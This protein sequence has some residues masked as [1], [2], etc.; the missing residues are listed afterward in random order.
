QQH[1]FDAI[2]GINDGIALFDKDERLVLFNRRCAAVFSDIANVFKP[3][4]GFEDFIRALAKSGYYGPVDE[5]WIQTRLHRFRAREDAEYA[6]PGADGRP[7]WRAARHHLTS[8]GETL[9]VLTDITARKRAEAE[10]ESTRQLLQTALDSITDGVALF[11]KDE[12]LT[13]FN[14]NFVG[15]RPQ[16][17]DFVKPGRTFAEIIGHLV[18]QGGYM[19][20]DKDWMETRLR[21]FRALEPAELHMCDPDGRERWADVRHYRTRDGGTFLVRTVITTRKRAEAE[22]ESAQQLL[23]TALDS[24]TGGVALF[25]KDERLVM[26][27]ENYIGA[28]P[29][30]RDFVRPGLTIAEIFGHLAEQGGFIDAEVDWVATRLRQFRALESAEIH[31]RDPDGRERWI[32]VRH[33]R[34]RDGGTFLVRADITERKR[35]EVELE[36]AR[37]RFADAIEGISDGV[38]LF[39]KDERLVQ[40]NRRYA[41]VMPALADILKPGVTFEDIV[42]ALAERSYYGPVDEVWITERLRRFRNLEDVEFPAV[43]PDGEQRWRALRHYRTRDGGTLLIRTDITTRKRAEAELES[44]RQLLQ[45]ALDSMTDG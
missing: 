5:A 17:R 37:Q 26:F 22:R 16:L 14:E 33:Y 19:E 9:L 7:E 44:A 39:D 23:Q 4:L 21:Q 36:S 38:A 28:R 8:N 34:T 13:L 35:M 18:K 3:G 6:V 24:M 27:N 1:L 41:A 43:E 32:N 11:D 12:R 15:A 45:T 10:R 25:D 31:I 42:R 40:F 29:Q 30:L 2:E 20:A